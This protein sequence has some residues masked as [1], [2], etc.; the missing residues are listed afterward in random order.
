[1]GV[2][3]ALAALIGVPIVGGAQETKPEPPKWLKSHEFLS[4]SLAVD[5]K[6]DIKKMMKIMEEHRNKQTEPDLSDCV[7]VINTNRMVNLKGVAI[8]TPTTHKGSPSVIVRNF[9]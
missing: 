7:H 6:L 2:F 9:T 4:S 5:P 8:M 1:L 3:G